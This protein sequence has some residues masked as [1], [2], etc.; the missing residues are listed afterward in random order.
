MTHVPPLLNV[1]QEASDRT[2]SEQKADDKLRGHAARKIGEGSFGIH[3]NQHS[4]LFLKRQAL[5]RLLYYDDLYRRIVHVPGVICEFGVQWGATMATLANLRGIHEPFNHSRRIIGFDTF[6]GFAG[7]GREDGDTVRD[8]GYA[9][10]AGYETELA[11][12]LSIHESFSP[13][14]QLRKFE[15]IKGDVVDTL[16]AWLEAN[17][18]SIVGMAIFDMDIYRPT[19]A[20]LEAVL[21]R[22]VHGSLLVFDEL[23]CPHF[24]GETQAVQEVLGLNRL[25]LRRSPLQPWCAFAEFEG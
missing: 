2:S 24:P 1:R 7:V 12:I 8:G 5:S 4:T 21:P 22:L 6:G 19:K 16:P 15:L 23:S 14:P 20:A 10:D 17:P 25:R 9:T 18:A 13:I 3:W 11:D